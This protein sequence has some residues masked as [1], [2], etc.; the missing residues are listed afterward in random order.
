MFL[1]VLRHDLPAPTAARS[2]NKSRFLRADARGLAAT[3]HAG[4]RCPLLPSPLP[5]G[6]SAPRECRGLLRPGPTGR[7]A[8]RDGNRRQGP[9]R[10][11]REQGPFRHY[12]PPDPRDPQPCPGA[13]AQAAAEG[14]HRRSARGRRGLAATRHRRWSLSPS[15]HPPSGVPRL[16]MA[17]AEPS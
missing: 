7:P 14:R 10:A 13:Q 1:R 4:L 3:P 12:P 8:A 9:D 5:K 2:L 15:S 16:T 11:L 6:R 17:A